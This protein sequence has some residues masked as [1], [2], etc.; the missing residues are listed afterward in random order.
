MSF[1]KN[2][3]KNE[4]AKSNNFDSFEM[5]IRYIFNRE[6]LTSEKEFLNKIIDESMQKYA[7]QEAKAYASWLSNQIIAGRTGA[8]LFMDYKAEL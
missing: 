2:E 3:C 8:K 5:A 6:L 7:D 4:I 1:T